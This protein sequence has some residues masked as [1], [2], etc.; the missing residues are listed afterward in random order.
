VRDRWNEFLVHTLFCSPF[1]T[2]VSICIHLKEYFTEGTHFLLK[3]CVDF[4]CE[5]L[6]D[7]K[8]V[9]ENLIWPSITYPMIPLNKFSILTLIFFRSSETTV[10]ML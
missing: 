5:Q 1:S 9:P 4:M 6:W 10:C 3:L 2:C 8:Q 7:F